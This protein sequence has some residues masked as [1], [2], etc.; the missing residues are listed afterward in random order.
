MAAKDELM[1]NIGES[2]GYVSIMIDR[3]IEQVKLDVAEKSASTVSGVISGIILTILGGSFSLF[4]LIALAF[5]LGGENFRSVAGGFGI[6]ALVLFVLFL[7]IFFLRR[8]LIVNP[9]V[10]KVIN[11][12]FGKSKNA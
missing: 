2:V 8:Q 3:K 5:Y 4:G 7:I 1:E 11:I 6:I 12:F 10:D 9:T